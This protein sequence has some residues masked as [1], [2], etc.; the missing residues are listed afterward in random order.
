[1]AFHVA[2]VDLDVGDAVDGEEAV[3]VGEGDL[4]GA[5]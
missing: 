4:A 2:I 1:M 3:A 5:E